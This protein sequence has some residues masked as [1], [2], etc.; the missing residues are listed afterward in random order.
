MGGVPRE[1]GLRL[2]RLQRR[3]A[4]RLGQVPVVFYNA[5]GIDRGGLP[6]DNLDDIAIEG[7]VRFRATQDSPGANFAPVFGR[8]IHAPTWMDIAVLA[9][10]MLRS[11]HDR[12]RRF[13]T[14]V[15]VLAKVDGIKTAQIQL[16]S[17]ANARPQN[18][19]GHRSLLR[20]VS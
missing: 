14:G 16:D 3:I 10:G 12:H 6:I 18:A 2:L 8:I 1:Y 11:S 7:R 13:L 20:A 5:Y 17:W 4:R 9:D 15:R 19:A